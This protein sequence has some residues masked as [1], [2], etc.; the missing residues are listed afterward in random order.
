MACAW[1]AADALGVT[2][3]VETNGAPVLADAHRIAQA[4][5]NLLGNAIKYAPGGTV[6][7]GLDVRGSDAVVTVTDDGIGIPADEFDRLFDRFFRASTARRGGFDGSGIGLSV[8]QR[9]VETH[10]GTLGV[11]SVVG[12]GTTFRLT[13]PLRA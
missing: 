13:L 7:I 4:L 6:E 12:E 9:I 5:D 1:P 11:E 8:V 3:L 10:G 2:L